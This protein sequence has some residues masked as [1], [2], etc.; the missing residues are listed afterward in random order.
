MRRVVFVAVK[1]YKSTL[2]SAIC[3]LLFLTRTTCAGPVARAVA[4]PDHGIWSCRELRVLDVSSVGLLELPECVAE[5][6]H[7][8]SLFVQQNK[9]RSVPS[10]L[11]KLVMSPGCS[12]KHISLSGNAIDESTKKAIEQCLGTVSA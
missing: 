3:S 4:R 1:G 2:N 6:Q 10:S 9:L 8:E 7:L 11:L 5:L 12:L